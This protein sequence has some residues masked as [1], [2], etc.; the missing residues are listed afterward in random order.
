MHGAPDPTIHQHTHDSYTCSS[1]C[2]AHSDACRRTSRGKLEAAR[3]HGDEGSEKNKL[4]NQRTMR[5]RNHVSTAATALTA[6]ACA[7]L[8]L[9]TVPYLRWH[10]HPVSCATLTPFRLTRGGLQTLDAATRR[11]ELAFGIEE[12]HITD[13]K[14]QDRCDPVGKSPTIN[15]PDDWAPITCED[16]Q[17][18]E[19]A[20][21][22]VYTPDF[23]IPR[24]IGYYHKHGRDRPSAGGSV[25]GV[26]KRPASN[27]VGWAWGQSSGTDFDNGLAGMAWEDAGHSAPEDMA[28]YIAN[29][30]NI[31]RGIGYYAPFRDPL[32]LQ[33]NPAEP[34]LWD[35]ATIQEVPEAGDLIPRGLGFYSGALP[36]AEFL[37]P[38]LRDPKFFASAHRL[39]YPSLPD[40]ESRARFFDRPPGDSD[41]DAPCT[42][43][44]E[45]LR[46]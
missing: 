12:V 42:A 10:L 27:S 39:A 26:L 21:H 7:G 38:D 34:I 46:C 16:D 17:P 32:Q 33:V 30:S 11:A 22:D 35:R 1:T 31:S 8:I 41:D 29:Y 37:E 14:K 43:S 19:I 4:T 40:T 3:E 25:A 6:A 23:L 24:G 45:P 13:F 18:S 36:D 20:N 9:Q 28:E 2:G 15:N 5:G 44:G